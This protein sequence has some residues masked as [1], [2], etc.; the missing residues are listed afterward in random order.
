[1]QAKAA[2]P[3]ST[4]AAAQ[5]ALC[6]RIVPVVLFLFSRPVSQKPDQQGPSCQ[7]MRV[8]SKQPIAECGFHHD[9]GLGDESVA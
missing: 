5:L 7:R 6:V 1:M 2:T 4:A 9:G 3:L 8:L